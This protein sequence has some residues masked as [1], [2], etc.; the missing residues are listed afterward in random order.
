MTQDHGCSVAVQCLYDDLARLDAGLGKRA[1]KHFFSGNYTVL[2]VEEHNCKN[3]VRSVAQQQPEIVAHSIW[4]V[5]E[6]G[7]SSFA[8]QQFKSLGNDG[9]SHIGVHKVDDTTGAN[10]FIGS[11]SRAVSGQWPGGQESVGWD[12]NWGHRVGC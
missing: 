5:Q 9:V 4:T 2:G 8:G 7:F 11:A 1:A 3:L 12:K 10:V 6:V